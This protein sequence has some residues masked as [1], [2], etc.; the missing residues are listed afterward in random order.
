MGGER[1]GS[2][3]CDI[4]HR[5]GCFPWVRTVYLIPKYLLTRPNEN[6]SAAASDARIGARSEAMTSYVK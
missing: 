2:C 5:D 6:L 3:V 4:D 1:F